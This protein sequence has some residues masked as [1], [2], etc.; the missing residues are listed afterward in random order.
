MEKNIVFCVLFVGLQGINENM[1]KVCGRWAGRES[2]GH[3]NGGIGAKEGWQIGG[4]GG[5]R[6][7]PWPLGLDSGV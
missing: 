6:I 7:D 2:V 3:K 4:S 1:L 5:R